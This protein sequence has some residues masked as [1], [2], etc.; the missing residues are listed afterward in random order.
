MKDGHAHPDIVVESASLAAVAPPR[1]TADYT[2]LRAE[3]ERRAIS[4]LQLE[5]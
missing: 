3:W 1:I 5:V 2:G 4:N